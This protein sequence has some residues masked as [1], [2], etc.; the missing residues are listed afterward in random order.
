MATFQK[1]GKSWRVI[2]T[3]RGVRNSATFATKAEAHAWATQVEAEILAGKRGEIPDRPFAHL[4]ERY[5]REVSPTKRG[6]RWEQIRI[7]RFLDDP[8]AKIP[9][10]KLDQTFFA[11]W[12]D[13]RLKAISPASVIREWT[14]LSHACNI[15]VR[16]WRW[17]KENPMKGIRRPQAPKARD[18]RIEERE[19][20]RLLWALGY[21]QN[22]PPNTVSARVGAA[23]LFAIETAL[24][25]GEISTLAWTD[26][27]LKG[28]YLKVRAVETG[29][30]KTHAAR[31]EVPLSTEAVRLLNQLSSVRK[32][33]KRSENRDERVFRVSSTQ[34]DALFR[35]AKGK[36][37]IEDLHFHDTR[38]EAITRLA[39]KLGVLELARMVG[40]RD[41][42]MLMVYYNETAQEL[43]KKLD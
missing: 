25:A 36:A 33:R 28:R 37:M 1:R 12:R 5:A 41:L 39:K 16:E 13:R 40:H 2:V 19:I 38:H 29:G 8:I 15:A 34:I 17:L 9:L 22:D 31:R 32:D 14:L 21:E 7:N 18:R 4:L 6:A 43:S 35:K 23:M 27:F 3:R 10:T 11:E 26:V 42:K 24:R 20:E 30:G